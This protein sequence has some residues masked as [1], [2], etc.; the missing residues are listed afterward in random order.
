MTVTRDRTIHFTCTHCGAVYSA[1][2][3]DSPTEKVFLLFC[4]E[5]RNVLH[6][7]TGHYSL[8]DLMQVLPNVLN[9]RD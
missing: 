5:C 3:S 1:V 2:R 4:K 6:D 7:S 9:S 8:T